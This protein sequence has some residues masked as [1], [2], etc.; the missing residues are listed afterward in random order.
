MAT[1]PAIDGKSDWSLTWWL[2]SPAKEIRR[3]IEAEHVVVVLD[4]VLVQQEVELL[5]LRFKANVINSPTALNQSLL[6]YY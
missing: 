4:V 5:Q 1:Q 3:V 6:C 2:K